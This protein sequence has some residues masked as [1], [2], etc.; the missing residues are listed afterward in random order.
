MLL[1]EIVRHIDKCFTKKGIKEA[2]RGVRKRTY[3]PRPALIKIP[4]EQVV[5]PE[6]GNL[7]EDLS[8]KVIIA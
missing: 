8:F 3:Q 4:S 6:E 1:P 5:K 2:Q 7:D